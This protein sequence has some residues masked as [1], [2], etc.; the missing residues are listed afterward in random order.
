MDWDQL[1]TEYKL[2][3]FKKTTIK[4]ILNKYLPWIISLYIFPLGII[5]FHPHLQVILDNYVSYSQ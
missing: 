5:F 3:Q 1:T 4:R 2:Q